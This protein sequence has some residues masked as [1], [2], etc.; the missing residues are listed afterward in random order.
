MQQAPVHSVSG[1][2]LGDRRL[3]RLASLEQAF[4][5]IAQRSGAARQGSNAVAGQ[6]QQVADTGP[7]SVDRHK[8]SRTGHLDLTLADNTTA[9]L[10]A[11]QM[12]AV[13][14]ALMAHVDAQYA[15]VRPLREAIYAAPT[16]A[17][18][19]AVAWPG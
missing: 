14:L 11:G 1:D 3:D 2:G 6:W 9:T 4:L 17:A 16:V 8:R 12:I 13:G 5:T 10:N 7:S 19:E 15:A 18:V